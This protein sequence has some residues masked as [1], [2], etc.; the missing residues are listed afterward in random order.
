MIKIQEKF[1]ILFCKLLENKCYHA[2][3]PPKRF[4]LNGHT[5]GFC[6]QTQ[7]L[8]LHYIVPV[9]IVDSGGERVSYNR[10]VS[11]V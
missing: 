5:V 2:K 11:T 1:Q 9:S 7:K 10:S 8:E 4:H 3:V 6:Q